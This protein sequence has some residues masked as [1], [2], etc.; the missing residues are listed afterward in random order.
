MSELRLL[1]P[2]E[3]DGIDLPGGKPRA[4][5]ARLALDAGRVVAADALL[6]ALWGERPPP[7]A[8]KVLQAHVS[9][10]R[11]VLGP[12]RSRPAR[13]VMSCAVA[14]RIWRSSSRWPSRRAAQP[15]AT[16]RAQLYR[17]CARALARACAR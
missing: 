17:G 10:L 5:L 4:V 9:T 6:E 2:L 14:R 3:V 15:D 11:K 13:P 8:H 1:G 16:R 12:S 7:S